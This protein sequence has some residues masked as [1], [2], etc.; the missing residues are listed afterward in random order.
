MMNATKLAPWV[1]LASL[2]GCGLIRIEGADAPVSG[3]PDAKA[4][5]AS[6]TAANAGSAA[7]E[8]A[9]ETWWST[10]APMAQGNAKEIDAIVAS[11][12]NVYAKEAAFAALWKKTQASDAGKDPAYAPFLA[13][14]LIRG[15]EKV[16]GERGVGEASLPFV[17]EIGIPRAYGEMFRALGSKEEEHDRFL[18]L[19]RGGAAFASLGLDR[20]DADSPV[21]G[22]RAKEI[23]ALFEA[24]KKDE[25]AFFGQKE[26]ERKGVLDPAEPGALVYV[27]AEG[28]GDKN[29]SEGR[30]H[31]RVSEVTPTSF[32]VSGF[33]RKSTAYGCKA[34]IGKEGGVAAVVQDCKYK[35]EDTPIAVIV[36]TSEL[37]PTG[38]QA[39]DMVDLKATLASKTDSEKKIERRVRDAYVVKVVRDGKPIF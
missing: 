20:Y 24:A 22:A 23:T 32:T 14:Q 37:P 39:G 5:P 36:E 21:D 31:L 8:R 11:K 19:G 3:G 33:S 29:I 10:I 13:F 4:E 35:H 9:F 27:T 26:A 34:A 12:D 16:H 38:L 1:L 30:S 2:T 15:V 28:R 17:I 7:E 18:V 6:G 25:K